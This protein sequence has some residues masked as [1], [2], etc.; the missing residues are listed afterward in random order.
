MSEECEVFAGKVDRYN[1]LTI[2]TEQI[3]INLES[4][5]QQLESKHEK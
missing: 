2:D 4:F 1:G 3:P 5:P